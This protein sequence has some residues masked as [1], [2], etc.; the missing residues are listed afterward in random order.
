MT[1]IEKGKQTEGDAPHWIEWV[2]GLLSTAL[3]IGML[4][5]V[6]YEAV[7]RGSENPE[8]TIQ[9]LTTTKVA[10]GYRV[11]FEIHNSATTTAAAVVVRGEI[12]TN[13]TVAEDAEVTFDYVPS[14]SKVGGALIFSGDPAAGELRIR[15]VGYT[16]P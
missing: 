3:V 13:Q 15:P 14:Q 11:E 8:L 1:T 16:D 10:A 12:M 6:G 2:T 7:T 9:T 4:G 5:W